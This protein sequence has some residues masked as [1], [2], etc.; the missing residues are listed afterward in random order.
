MVGQIRLFG[1]RKCGMN[2]EHEPGADFIT[3]RTGGNSNCFH[4]WIGYAWKNETTSE[5]TLEEVV[6]LELDYS[7]GFYCDIRDGQLHAGRDPTLATTV[8]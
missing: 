5:P 1:C 2:G 8:I 7:K 6:K 3:R 4:I